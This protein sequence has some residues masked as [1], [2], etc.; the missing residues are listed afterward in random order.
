MTIS[1]LALPLLSGMVGE[2]SMSPALG[3]PPKRGLGAPGTR[4]GI[5]Q[6]SVVEGGSPLPTGVVLSTC[7]PQPTQVL[8]SRDWR[9]KRS[10]P[11]STQ[12]PKGP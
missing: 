12:V 2:A 7:D 10:R 5:A 3:S 11:D 9:P 4:G 1:D 8:N 6:S